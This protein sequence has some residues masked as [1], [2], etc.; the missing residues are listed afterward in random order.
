M[1]EIIICIGDGARGQYMPQVAFDLEAKGWNRDDQNFLLSRQDVGIL[2][3]GPEHYEYWDLWDEILN[4]AVYV[5]ESGDEWR[6]V[7]QDGDLFAINT[8]ALDRLSNNSIEVCD[9]CLLA[10]MNDDY[11]GVDYYAT[12]EQEAGERIKD[13][14]AGIRY[15][16]A[17]YTTPPDILQELDARFENMKFS[18]LPCDCCGD[19][20]PG[21]R[22]ILIKSDI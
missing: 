22:T 1:P 21:E 19:N 2:E 12:D 15:L 13:I 7:Q 5:D 4:D 10:L 14:K 20:L 9:D 6:L 11:T 18:R 17:E 8:P 3:T 16:L